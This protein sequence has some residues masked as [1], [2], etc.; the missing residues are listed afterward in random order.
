MFYTPIVVLVDMDNTVFDLLGAVE[1]RWQQLYPDK[2]VPTTYNHWGVPD[3][4]EALYPGFGGK[5]ADDIFRK[6]PDLFDNLQPIEGVVEAFNKLKDKG[7]E[8]FF[9]TSS[10]SNYKN[11]VMKHFGPEW[12]NRI[13]LTKDKT[14]VTGV[15][16]IDDA[17]NIE[18]C[19]P[20]SW[21]HI[22]YKQP[23][24]SGKFT[25]RWMLDNVDEFVEQLRVLKH[26]PRDHSEVDAILKTY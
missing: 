7:C 3:D 9:C 5:A 23:Y 16:L 26:L 2:P 14:V 4:Y 24:N 19:V 17:L 12:L 11:C 6:S 8:V 22:R 15:V 10:I 20:P 18:G 21:Y 25:W 13:I 1:K